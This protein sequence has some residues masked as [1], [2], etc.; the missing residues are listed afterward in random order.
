M[1][2]CNLGVVLSN[3][4]FKCTLQGNRGTFQLETHKL[5]QSKL[6]ESKERTAT[7]QQARS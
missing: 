6:N 3:G 2:Q 7:I 1:V 5:W 4:G